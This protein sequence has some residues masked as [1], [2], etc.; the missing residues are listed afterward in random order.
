MHS[1]VVDSHGAFATCK[2]TQPL[3]TSP[4]LMAAAEKGRSHLLTN[5]ALTHPVPICQP[6][7]FPSFIITL[8]RMERSKV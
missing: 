2:V 7:L 5:I 4:E 8:S 6:I 3:Y 1:N